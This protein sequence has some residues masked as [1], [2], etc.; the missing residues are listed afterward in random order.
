M[1]CLYCLLQLHAIRVGD[2][3]LPLKRHVVVLNWNQQAISLL[4]QL[5]STQADSSSRLY[6]RPIVVLADES[7]AGLDAAVAAVFK[8]SQLRLF[9]RSGRPAKARDLEMVAAET[10][11]TVIILHPESCSSK[12]AADAL[13]ATALVS[14]TCLR[15]RALGRTPAS[16][17]RDSTFAGTLLS[18][19]AAVTVAACKSTYSLLCAVSAKLGSTQGR[20]AGTIANRRGSSPSMRIVVQ[21]ASMPV[22]GE[23]V[24]GFLQDAA[25]SSF[26][27]STIQQVQLLNQRTLYR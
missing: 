15:E 18:G 12:A 3:R 7:K 21:M 6:R 16:V 8:G 17:P 24:I 26:N 2:V 20:P 13:K 11:D 4:K 19:L 5:H 25:A 10:A 27:S 22:G 23:D 9:C 14:L 1:A